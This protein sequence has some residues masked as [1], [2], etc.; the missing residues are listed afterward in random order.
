VWIIIVFKCPEVPLLCKERRRGGRNVDW[1]QVG[2][3]LELIA[4]STTLPHLNPPLTKGRRFAEWIFENNMGNQ[5]P[6]KTREC[7]LSFLLRHPV[8]L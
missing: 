1:E 6:W 7:L 5:Y 3:T 4:M 8:Y 2:S